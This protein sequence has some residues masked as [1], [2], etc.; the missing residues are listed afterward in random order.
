MPGLYGAPTAM[1]PVLSMGP[2]YAGVLPSRCELFRIRDRPLARPRL[3]RS[4][5]DRAFRRWVFLRRLL[6]AL[7]HI[8]RACGLRPAAARDIFLAVGR[9]DMRRIAIEVGS[10]DAKILAIR[11]DPFPERLG[12]DPAL[13]LRRALGADDVGRKPVAITAAGAAAVIRAV[14]RR[15]QAAGDRLPVVVAERA[16]DAGL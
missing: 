1:R 9:S 6:V 16:G 14:A 10:P 12:R 15:L 3:R 8:S 13:R 7:L 2:A 5:G 4:G 11:I